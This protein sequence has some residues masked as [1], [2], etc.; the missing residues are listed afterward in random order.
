MRVLIDTNVVLDV[1]FNRKQFYPASARAM[2]LA[3]EDQIE[4]YVA[5]HAVTTIF[6]VVERDRGNETARVALIDLLSIMKVAAVDQGVI[7]KALAA[8]YRDFEDAVT[9]MAAASIGADYIVTR[10]SADFA[11]GP[12]PVLTPVEL[13]A[14]L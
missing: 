2:T 12:L 5:A 6:Y 1:I 7:E 13:L 3:A 9:M 10:N 14:R 4:G 8:P 11:H